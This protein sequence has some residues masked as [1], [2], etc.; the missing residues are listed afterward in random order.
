LCEEENRTG[1][2]MSTSRI[3]ELVEAADLTALLRAVDDLV[4]TRSWEEMIYLAEACEDAVERGKQLWPIAQHIDYRL[5]LEA[6]A[7]Y[8]AAVLEPGVARF[9]LGPLTEVCA[10]THSWA[11]L[12]PHL[13]DARSSAYV[14]QERV[15]RGENL[16]GEDRAHP[17]VL[18]LPLHLMSFEPT[19]A[20][21][22]YR[23]S[24][25]E[26]AEPWEPLGSWTQTENSA[27]APHIADDELREALLD[28]VRPWTT[29]SNGEAAVAVVEGDATGAIGALARAKCRRVLLEPAEAMQRVAWAASSGGAHGRRRGAAYGRFA[30]WCLWALAAGLELPPAPEELA[31]SLDDLAWYL[32]DEGE[33]K[34]G[35]VLRLGLEHRDGWAA[36]LSAHDRLEEEGPAES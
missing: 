8:A 5:A 13:D 1:R 10:S 29:E 18:E 35:W 12:A 30:A 3:G 7:E 25:V 9:A 32:W 2:S 34:K 28:L 31:R 27:P 33:A 21:A 19:Y 22:T 6:P 24:Y 20:L 36:A 14:A 15:L 16:E 4:A 17:E 23:A 11:E 26:V